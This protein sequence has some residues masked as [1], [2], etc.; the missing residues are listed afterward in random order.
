VPES[1]TFRIVLSDGRVAATDEDVPLG[2]RPAVFARRL[3]AIAGARWV[4]VQR[5]LLFARTS[6]GWTSVDSLRCAPHGVRDCGV[7]GREDDANG[8]IRGPVPADRSLVLRA[9]QAVPA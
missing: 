3:A 8:L 7:C 4:G 2:L 9:R 6:R 1:E 5:G